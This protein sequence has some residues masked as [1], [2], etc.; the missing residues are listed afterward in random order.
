MRRP[1]LRQSLALMC[2]ALA[3]FWP[4]TAAAEADVAASDARAVFQGHG[5][6]VGELSAWSDGVTS[7]SVSDASAAPVRVFV[8]ADAAAAQ[9]Y[10]ETRIDFIPAGVATDRGP[11]LL[12]G[13]GASAWRGNLA[14]VQQTHDPAAFAPEPECVPDPVYTDLA[15][16]PARPAPATGVDARFLQVLDV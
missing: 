13:Y 4:A 16:Q 2:L 11:R 8:F 1:T 12:S 6:G 7:F 10:R 5:F 3:S 14:L 9:A 15:P